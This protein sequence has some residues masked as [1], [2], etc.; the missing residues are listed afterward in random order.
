MCLLKPTHI[1]AYTRRPGLNAFV[2]LVDLAVFGHRRGWV[3][4]EQTDVIVQGLLIALQSQYIVRPLLQHL[5]G[6]LSLAVHGI[7]GHHHAGQSLHFQQLGHCGNLVGFAVHSQ[8]A[9]DLSISKV[10]DP[11]IYTVIDPPRERVDL[12]IVELRVAGQS[13]PCPA[14]SNARWGDWRSR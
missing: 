12:S 3:F 2:P 6:L 13:P 14:L 7:G 4:E 1:A 10:F 8:L 11:G 9:Q 5:L